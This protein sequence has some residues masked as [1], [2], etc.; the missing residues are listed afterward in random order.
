MALLGAT[1]GL[2]FRQLA[3]FLTQRVKGDSLLAFTAVSYVGSTNSTLY[4][5]VEALIN[6]VA[7]HP[8]FCQQGSGGSPQIVSRPASVWKRQRFGCFAAASHAL[9]RRPLPVTELLAEAFY[10]DW[11]RGITSREDPG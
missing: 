3:E 5:V 9:I 2:A 7:A 6:H 8:E 10:A 4:H 1:A 11:A